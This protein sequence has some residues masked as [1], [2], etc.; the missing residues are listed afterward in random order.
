MPKHT[1]RREF[2]EDG[3][4]KAPPRAS[5][6]EDSDPIQTDESFQK[7]QRTEKSVTS[8]SK[9]STISSE[10][11]S[12]AAQHIED[13]LAEFYDRARAERDAE[14]HAMLVHMV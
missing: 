13:P 2:T 10:K 8:G 11:S 4:P 6:T 14:V 5:L 1:F 7:S 12:M 3:A 9:H